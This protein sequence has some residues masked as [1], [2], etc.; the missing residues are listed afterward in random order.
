MTVTEK[1]RTSA[2]GFARWAGVFLVG[3]IIGYGMMSFAIE[4]PSAEELP[5]Q[6]PTEAQPPA[7]VELPSLNVVDEAQASLE[8]TPIAPTTPAEATEK[9]VADLEPKVL[10]AAPAPPEIPR[11]WWEACQDRRCRLDFGGISGNLTIRKATL[12]HGSTI[13]WN[14]DM[15]GK[16]RIESL[17]T[18][19]PLE[20]HVQAI[21]MNADGNPIAA[22]IVWRRRGRDIRGVITLDLGEPGKRIVMHP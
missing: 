12:V 15:G 20:V 17:P 9:A 7:P 11:P 2:A 22:E 21:A 13:D 16:A 10:D 8:S 18:D 5:L 14:A 3:F 1:L 4:A 6:L 19:R